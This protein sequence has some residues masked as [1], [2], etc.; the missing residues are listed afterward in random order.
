MKVLIFNWKVLFNENDN[1]VKEVAGEIVRFALKN[2]L[3]VGI[4]NRADYPKNFDEQ[5]K[6]FIGDVAIQK[7]AEHDIFLHTGMFLDEKS[8]LDVIGRF[9][10]KR[11][12]CCY[13]DSEHGNIIAAKN[14]GLKTICV[15]EGADSDGKETDADYTVHSLGKIKEIISKY[16]V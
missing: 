14:L 15:I 13:I 9:E 10:A 1:G 12:N 4:V 16:V 7:H 2:G 3:K 5:I 11:E 8:I 6:D